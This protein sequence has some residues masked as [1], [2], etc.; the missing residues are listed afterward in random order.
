MTGVDDSDIQ[1][2]D[3]EHLVEKQLDN[4]GFEKN[5]PKLHTEQQM[6]EIEEFEEHVR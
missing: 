2:S 6:K 3:E 5:A 4:F 1:S